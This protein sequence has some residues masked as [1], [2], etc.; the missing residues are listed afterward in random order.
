M[1]YQFEHEYTDHF[2]SV[3]K[4]VQKSLNISVCP[5]KPKEYILWQEDLFAIDSVIVVKTDC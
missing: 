2:I 5:L 4:S 1:P 3:V